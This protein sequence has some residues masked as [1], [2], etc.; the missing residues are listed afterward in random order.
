MS[1]VEKAEALFDAPPM[2][3]QERMVEAILFAS[4]EA[5]TL[6]QI[7]ERMPHGSDAG[8]ALAL[9]RQGVRP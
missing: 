7:G 2:T 8:G 6:T 4:A 3:E 1:V 5:L 9:L